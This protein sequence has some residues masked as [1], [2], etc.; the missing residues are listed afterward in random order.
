MK[1]KTEFFAMLST[2]LGSWG[3]DTPPEAIWTANELVDWVEKEFDVKIESRF[4]EAYDEEFEDDHN[5]NVIS[6]LEQVLGA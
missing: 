5:D 3:G 1:N 2:L 6:E 4:A